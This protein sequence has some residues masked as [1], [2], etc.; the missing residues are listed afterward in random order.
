[1]LNDF[2]RSNDVASV[3]EF[4]CGDGL[5]KHPDRT[6]LRSRYIECLLVLGDTTGAWTL[7]SDAIDQGCRE[8]EQTARK[9]APRP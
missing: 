7:A 4:G 9:L 8:F 6:T 2:V 3:I 1:V 5:Q